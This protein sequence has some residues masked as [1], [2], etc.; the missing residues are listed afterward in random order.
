M[1]VLAVNIVGDHAAERDEAC[2][3]RNWQEESVRNDT[4][5]DFAQG[6]ACFGC[7]R[8]GF[9]VKRDEAIEAGHGYQPPRAIQRAIAIRSLQADRQN[10][11]GW[12]R[13]KHSGQ[14]ISEAWRGDMLRAADDPPPR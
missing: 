13:A 7:Q 11:A 10:V 9:K 14:F 6:N 3:G 2:A 8:S 12:R 1:M 5:H 4:P